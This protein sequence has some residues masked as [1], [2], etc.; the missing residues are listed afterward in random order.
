MGWNI[1]VK[2]GNSGKW[3]RATVMSSKDR[4][5]FVQIQPLEEGEQNEQENYFADDWDAAF[6]GPGC[7]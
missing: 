4:C 2:N 7:V 6:S 1:L 3:L 5:T